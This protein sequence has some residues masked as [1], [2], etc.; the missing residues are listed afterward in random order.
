MTA[1]EKV[2]SIMQKHLEKHPG[3]RRGAFRAAMDYLQTDKRAYEEFSAVV[4][5]KAPTGEKNLDRIIRRRLNYMAK[6]IQR[7][8]LRR[9]PR[10]SWPEWNCRRRAVDGE[11]LCLEHIG[12]R[13]ALI[14][15]RL[16]AEEA[17]PRVHKHDCPDCKRAWNCRCRGK[18]VATKQCPEC[19]SRYE[20]AVKRRASKAAA[21]Q[22]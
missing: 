18:S 15:K 17:L 16:K 11:S 10:C 7:P 1:E 8:I 20:R 13:K 4:K 6:N 2:Q 5:P 12:G 9:R 3:G 19:Y 14:A 21:N 22:Q